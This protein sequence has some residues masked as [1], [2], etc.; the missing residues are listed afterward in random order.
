MNHDLALVAAVLE[1]RDM[2]D[3]ISLGASSSLLGDDA[4]VMWELIEGH[5]ERFHEVPSP[6]YFRKE[7]APQYEHQKPEDSIDVIIHA[8]KTNTLA[9]ELDDHLEE[10]AQLNLSDPWEARA[11]A[12]EGMERI[13]ARHSQSNTDHVVGADKD[14][15]LRHLARCQEGGGLL[16]L[17]WPWHY[18]NSG[19]QGLQLG[20]CAYFYGRQ[21]SKKTF[22]LLYIALYYA[23]VCGVRVLFFT[24]EM[25]AR[26]LKYRAYPM[27]LKMG[28]TDWKAGNLSSSQREQL[29]AVMDELFETG[30][31]IICDQAGD[32]VTGFKAKIEEKKP[33]V[34]IHDFAFAMAKDMMGDRASMNQEHRY[35]GNMVDLVVDYTKSKGR[36]STLLC[37]HA[38]RKGEQSKGR[39]SDELAHSDH[40]SRRMDYAFRLI[41]EERTKRLAVVINVARDAEQ[42]GGWTL[43]GT[44]YQTFGD[45]L[46]SDVEWVEHIDEN[47]KEAEASKARNGVEAPSG[48]ATKFSPADWRQPGRQIRV[49]RRT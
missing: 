30:N 34:V 10:V 49:R 24:R 44:L 29:E 8:L 4:R 23:L 22:M 47:Q 17:P 2:T 21:K 28:I 39:S 40:I 36:F 6:A 37:G 27:A 26:E 46:S 11:K 43:D 18:L 33:R 9:N 7:L 1:S 20:Q 13:Q 38:N 48:E 15:V 12:S 45:Q 14:E 35:V 16:G 3:A 5:F 25:T 32:G 41:H 19:T 42:L 31:F